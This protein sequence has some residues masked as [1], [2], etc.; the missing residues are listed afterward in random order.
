M[1]GQTKVDK[2]VDIAKRIAFLRHCANLYESGGNSPISDEQYDDEYYELKD[3]SPND[4]FFDEVGGLDQHIYGTKVVHDKIMGSLEKSRDISEFSA[5]I[6]KNFVD[7]DVFIL[8]HKIDGLAISLHYNNGKLTRALTRGDG[9]TGVDCTSN[10][11]LVGG[12][13]PTINV[14]E[15]IEIRGE[16]FKDRS[17]FYKKW[18]TSVGGEYAN[19]RNF[20]AGSLNQK[21]PKVTK[22]RGLSFVA[23]EVV[24][25]DFNSEADKVIFIEKCGFN[26]LK[27]SSKLLKKDLTRAQI[28]E[29]VRVYMDNIDRVNLPYDIDGVVVKLCDIG[30]AKAMGTSDGG[31]R[32][33]SSRAVKFPP[34]VKET[35]LIGA[36][37]SVGRTGNV[38]PVGILKP[39][40]ISGAMISKVSLY[41]YGRI[42]SDQMWTIG[43]TVCVARKGDIIPQIV[44]IKKAGNTPLPIPL[45]C[46]CCNSILAWDATGVNL[47]CNNSDC[48]AQL[49]SAIDHWLSNLGVK[50]IGPGILNKLTSKDEFEWEGHAVIES[51]PELYYMLDN[52]RRSEHPFRKYA[53]LKEFFGEKAYQNIIDA[54]NSV[55]EITLPKFI[56]ALG[57]GKIGSMAKDIVAI[58]PTVN[59]IDNLTENDIQGIAG[60]GG[61]KARNF[62]QG[63]KDKRSQI[64]TLL[65]YITIKA[66]VKKSTKLAG[67]KF[68]F[69]GSFSKGRDE[70]EKIVEDNGG[71]ASSSVGKDVILCWDGS[72]SGSKLEKAK[73]NGNKIISETDFEAML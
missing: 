10:A 42:T 19:P 62:I 31:K 40:E 6:N 2:S 37:A 41:N 54:V 13:L 9:V 53:K 43:A 11:I 28:V 14:N 33:K 65:K 55:K 61:V 56:E 25:K 72:I 23:Y 16:C 58:A 22:D 70:L 17:D 51:L 29:A 48:S 47:I 39:V 46:P 45:N 57:I 35:I 52:D 24:G 7:G 44:K 15:K 27:D 59:D 18:H 34:E 38:T 4:P 73:K 36:E 63:W 49:A 68:C 5:W 32:P 1:N 66:D 8:Q 71:I 12:V 60:F 20:T 21:D 50:G 64:N 26:T 30:K 67:M 3:L 69:T